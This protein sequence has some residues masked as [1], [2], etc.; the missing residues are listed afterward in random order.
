M[1]HKS[2]RAFAKKNLVAVNVVRSWLRSL[3]IPVREGGRPGVDMVVT[4]ADGTDLPV[5]I[6]VDE[7]CPVPE[8]G[9]RVMARCVVGR[10]EQDALAA[11]DQ[12]VEAS[13]RS[14]QRP[15]R[16]GPERPL[17]EQGNPRKLIYRDEEFLVAIRHNEFRRT[18]NPPHDRW[19]KYRRAMHWISRSFFFKNYELCRRQLMDLEDVLQY[20][21]CLMV[22]FCSRYERVSYEGDR[23]DLQTVND[24]LFMQYL[25]QRF[26]GL[27]QILEKR[28]VS[29]LPSSGAVETILGVNA[30]DHHPCPDEVYQLALD[31]PAELA[32]ARAVWRG[33]KDG[34]IPDI[35]LRGSVDQ[36][37]VARK[38]ELDTSTPEARRKSAKTKLGEL[39][40]KM[41]HDE[42]MQVLTGVATDPAQDFSAR[43]EAFRQIK[44]HAKGCSLCERGVREEEQVASPDAAGA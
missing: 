34:E 2:K 32:E 27:Y 25:R 36:D 20:A 4:H 3:D 44:K 19:E 16:E 33:E 26:T 13:G 43:Q 23:W 18:P 31:N 7:F 40:G 14:P 29:T 12:I 22:N 1:A 28:E 11:F 5:A 15:F 38:C 42:M 41:P 17:N 37:Y 10:R 24:G 21:R 35:F 39:L 8:G 9:V 30:M 6:A